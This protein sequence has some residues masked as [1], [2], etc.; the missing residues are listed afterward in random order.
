[1]NSSNWEAYHWNVKQL[2][3]FLQGHST[4]EGILQDLERRGVQFEANAQ[5]VLDGQAW[6]AESELEA[7]AIG[8]FVIG[9]CAESED[10]SKEITIAHGYPSAGSGHQDAAELYTTY[11]VEPLY[12]YIDE[13]LDDQRAILALLNRYKQ[14]CEWFRRG[15]LYEKWKAD[16]RRGEHNLAR[17]LYEYLHDQG[18]EFHIEPMSASGE[19]DIISAQESDD[20]L[21]AD[22]KIFNPERSL[23]KEYLAKG[24]GQIYRYT[25]DYN[26]PFGYLIIY[27]TCADDLRLA[28]TNQTAAVPFLIH[29]NKTIFLVVI[30]IY[31]HE[32]SASKRGA[33][34][35]IEIS[36]N[37]LIS[38]VED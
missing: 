20:P 26:K 4:F 19:V 15:H 37:D 11:F 22:A 35:P 38:V 3:D 7:A 29:N 36:E 1:M 30:D 6:L 9:R 21:L 14:K 32:K 23:G 33:L 17:D 10:G 2:W 28:L 16:T 31:P 13:Q 5:S 8:R 18:L 34:N 27:K 12:E 25:V 24:V